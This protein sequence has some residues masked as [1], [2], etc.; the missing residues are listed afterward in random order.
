MLQK[1]L[2]VSVTAY[3]ED[4]RNMITEYTNSADTSKAAKNALF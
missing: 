1:G 3:V 2:K 4:I